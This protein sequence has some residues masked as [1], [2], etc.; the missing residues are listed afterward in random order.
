MVG[1][2][3]SGILSRWAGGGR[4]LGSETPPHLA[5]GQRLGEERGARLRRPRPRPPRAPASP[6]RPRPRRHARTR[7]GGGVRL[8]VTRPPR[9]ALQPPPQFPGRHMDRAS[10]SALRH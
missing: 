6:L 5:R 1:G 10:P 7:A 2:G 9:G 4:R 3:V 8:H